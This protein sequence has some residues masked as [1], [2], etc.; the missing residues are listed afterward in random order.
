MVHKINECMRRLVTFRFA[1]CLVLVLV[2]SWRT[3]LRAATALPRLALIYP[4]W[5][6][7]RNKKMSH[8]S[9]KSRPLVE[10]TSHIAT[11]WLYWAGPRH[12]L[13]SDFVSDDLSAAMVQVLW[14]SFDLV[15]SDFSSFLFSPI[16]YCCTHAFNGKGASRGICDGTI[17]GSV[18]AGHQCPLS[19]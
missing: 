4:I 17:R 12:C 7:R 2:A 15:S 3:S 18:I 13:G 5:F 16:F 9:L 6:P 11:C 10:F 19:A 8:V 14:L 1:S